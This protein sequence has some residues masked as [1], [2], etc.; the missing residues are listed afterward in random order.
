MKRLAVIGVVA[1]GSGSAAEAAT[2]T[3]SLSMDMTITAACTVTSAPALDFGSQGLLTSRVDV[4]ATLGVLCT[5]GSGYNILLDAGANSGNTLV[6][7]MAGTPSGFVGYQ[8]Y[9]D[10]TR[11]QV[12]GNKMGSDTVSATGAGV[13]QSFIL[14]GRLPAQTA[15]PV[16][17]YADSITIT[18]SY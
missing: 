8:I 13:E 11:T 3:A 2:V 10:A 6:R 15:R 12:W 9:R 17:A 4:T 7:L 14:Y 16:G 1:A 18:I 5:K